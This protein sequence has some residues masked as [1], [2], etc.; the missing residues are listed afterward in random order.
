MRPKHPE[1][2]RPPWRKLPRELMALK[3]FLNQ[4]KHQH[5][6]WPQGQGQP[7]LVIPGF[8][9]SAS[10]TQAIR[11]MLS[12][13]GFDAYDWGLGRNLGMKPGMTGR[14]LQQLEQLKTQ[15]G[16]ACALLGWSL[17]GVLARELARKKPALVSHVISLG[18]PIAGA[19]S[20]T[21]YPLFNALNGP[22]KAGG[23]DAQ[24]YAPPPV[25]CTAIYTRDDGI[26]NWQASLEPE[27]P[28]SENIEVRGSHL[29]L[30]FNPAVWHIVCHRLSPQT[31]DQPYPSTQ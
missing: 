1:L 23:F 31:K 5:P 21:L 17:G 3:E 26:V 11:A 24:R 27:T 14:L 13:Q 10:S 30:G 8:G 29:G 15:N 18:S 28:Q 19:H 12:A 16:Q 20:T 25:P 6:H 9:Q 7:V 22:G 4:A 2:L